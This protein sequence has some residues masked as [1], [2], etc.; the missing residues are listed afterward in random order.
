MSRIKPT[1]PGPVRFDNKILEPYLRGAASEIA[2]A[3]SDGNLIRD[4]LLL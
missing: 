4:M 2:H 1:M 3:I